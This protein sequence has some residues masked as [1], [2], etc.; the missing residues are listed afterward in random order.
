M[1]QRVSTSEV[2][3]CHVIGLPN[4][5]DFMCSISSSQ[6]ISGCQGVYGTIGDNSCNGDLA[7]P[8]YEPMSIGS[9]SCNCEECCKCL[10]DQ[11]VDSFSG[12]QVPDNSCNELAPPGV[13]VDFVNGG[14]GP[15][16]YCC[17]GGTA[18]PV[19]PTSPPVPPPTLAPVA[20]PTE[21]PV[22]CTSKCSGQDA[23]KFIH[24]LLFFCGYR[25][26]NSHD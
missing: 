22:A 20:A 6:I 15:Y 3:S 23:C 14:S 21:A 12:L 10:Q 26:K 8:W 24:L 25:R 7:C 11:F 17:D 2:H 18:A 1:Q 9:G 13:A 4:T 5:H 19:Q 16:Q